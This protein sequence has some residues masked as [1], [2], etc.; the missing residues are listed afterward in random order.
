MQQEIAETHALTLLAWLAGDE[1]LVPLFM[2]ATGSS[3]A[4]MRARAGEPEFLASLMDFLLMDDQWVLKGAEA[5]GIRAE[6]FAMIRAGLPGGAL[7]N[8]T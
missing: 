5:T 6:D 7:P 8:W 4:D 3:E 1:E 2:G